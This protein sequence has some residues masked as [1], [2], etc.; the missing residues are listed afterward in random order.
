MAKKRRKPNNRTRSSAPSGAGTA[1]K[2][3]PAGA[4]RSGAATPSKTTRPATDTGADTRGPSAASRA[5]A[6]KKELARTE[7]E[8]A[9]KRMARA[10]RMRQLVW[11]VG[12][13][14]VVAIGVFLLTRS[15]AS[16]RPSEPLPGELRTEA[17]WDANADQAAERAQIL[18]LPGHSTP[19]A[20]HEHANVQ[21]FVHGEPQTIPVNVGINE[22]DGAIESIHTHE[23]S[24]TVHIESETARQFTLGEF[25][26]VWGV[27]LTPSCLGGHCNDG[28]NRLRVYVDGEQV[29]TDPRDVPLDDQTVIVLTYGTEQEEP[30]PIPSTF[31][32]SSIQP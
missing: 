30:S 23:T 16:N 22:A 31:D 10:Q 29:S 26:G 17:P 14:A 4:P 32:F 6:E 12:L 3:P 13:G 19:L 25:F 9:R 5:R 8:A 24:G 2:S 18:G 7:R 21:I 15:D 27:R 20:M 11:I 28:D 1:V